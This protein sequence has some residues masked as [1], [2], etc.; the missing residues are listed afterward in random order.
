M[1][2]LEDGDARELGGFP[3]EAGPGRRGVDDRARGVAERDEVVGPL[4]DVPPYRVVDALRSDRE[5][6]SPAARGSA[7]QSGRACSSQ[8]ARSAAGRPAAWMPFLRLARLRW[9]R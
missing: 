8:F 9:W 6:L 2:Q 5:R 4:D 3:A 7:P 1:D